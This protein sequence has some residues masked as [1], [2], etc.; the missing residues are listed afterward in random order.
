MKI[1]YLKSFSK[2]LDNIKYDRVR[3][4]VIDLI[5]NIKKANSLSDLKNVKKLSGSKIAYRI[6]LGDYRVGF[7]FENNT[8]EL[9]KIQHRKD[10]Y[11][12]FPR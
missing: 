12:N 3:N 8:L 4:N 11:K 5:D 9:A 1:V 6:R 7:F 10:I 2:D